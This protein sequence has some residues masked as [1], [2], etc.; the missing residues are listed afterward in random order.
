MRDDKQLLAEK[1]NEMTEQI[2]NIIIKPDIHPW[3]SLGALLQSVLVVSAASSIPLEHLTGH[4]NHILN[5]PMA[6]SERN[7][8]E[9]EYK[10][11]YAKN[12]NHLAVAPK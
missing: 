6:I 1:L 3:D 2:C 5:E 7:R 9:A 8:M 4:I 11:E 12:K 10:R